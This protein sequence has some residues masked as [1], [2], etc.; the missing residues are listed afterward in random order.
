MPNSQPNRWAGANIT[1]IRRPPELSHHQASLLGSCVNSHSSRWREPPPAGNV[2][3]GIATL[4]SAQPRRNAGMGHSTLQDVTG[5]AAGGGTAFHCRGTKTAR[6]KSRCSSA[7]SNAATNHPVHFCC[8]AATVSHGKGSP[9]LMLGEQ[10]QILR[11]SL[12]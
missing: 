12:F 1:T 5:Y 7:E 11:R 3:I 2:Q 10:I 4:F 9:T 8:A 6:G